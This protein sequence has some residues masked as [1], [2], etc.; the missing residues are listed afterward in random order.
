MLQA[1]Q[2]QHEA[3]VVFQKVCRAAVASGHL[4]IFQMECSHRHNQMLQASS[5]HIGKA[6]DWLKMAAEGFLNSV[7]TEHKKIFRLGLANG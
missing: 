4:G 5:R 3:E 2:G 1:V 7:L 6:K